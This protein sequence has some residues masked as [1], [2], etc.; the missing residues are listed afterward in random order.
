[1]A[2]VVEG[3]SAITVLETRQMETRGLQEQYYSYPDTR[4]KFITDEDL[5]F[6]RKCPYFSQILLL[7]WK[8]TQYGCLSHSAGSTGTDQRREC[9]DCPVEG[10]QAEFSTFPVMKP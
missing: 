7:S 2:R 4:A 10:Q 8:S 3:A 1:M 9:P 5:L 6:P